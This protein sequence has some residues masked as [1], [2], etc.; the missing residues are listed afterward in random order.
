MRRNC[1]RMTR[2]FVAGLLAVTANAALADEASDEL[3]RE[4]TDP[5][6]SLMAFNFIVDYTF[7]FHGPITGDDDATVLSFRPVIPFTAW[8][9]SNILRVTI[10]YQNSGRGAEGLG[11]VSLFNVVVTDRP[12]GRFALGLVASLSPDHAAADEF[13]AGPAIGAVRVF[14]KKLSVGAFNQNVFAGDTAVSQIQP[15]VAYQLGNGWSLS[16]GDLQI[17][18]DWKSGRFVSIPVGF[19]IGKVTKLF[20]QPVRWSVN[21]QY[22][23]K[24]DA[25][26]EKFSTLFTFT[27]LVPG[28]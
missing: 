4:A 25:G 10:P 6:A 27:L 22:N 20:G 24:D 17:V 3:A 23:L 7:D 8:G 14:S 5:T 16:A 15:V 26:L 19:Q 2:L 13:S 28:K 9:R 11:S 1:L 18:Y 21:P 12:W